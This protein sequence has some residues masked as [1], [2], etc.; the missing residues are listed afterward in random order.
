MKFSLYLDTDQTKLT[1]KIKAV[2]T[3]ETS[4]LQNSIAVHGP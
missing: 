2:S 4:G 3:N 1:F